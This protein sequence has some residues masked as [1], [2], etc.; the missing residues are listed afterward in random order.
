MDN[1]VNFPGVTYGKIPPKTMAENL[2]EIAESLDTMLVC[3]HTKD[4]QFYFA[5]SEGEA[6]DILWLIENAKMTLWEDVLG[7]E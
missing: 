4:G 7:R 6:K 1:V 2:S 3:G 5:S